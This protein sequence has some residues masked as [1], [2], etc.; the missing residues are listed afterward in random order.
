MERAAEDVLRLAPAPWLTPIAAALALALTACLA[1]AQ[2][3]RVAH[4]LGTDGSLHSYAY[5]LNDAGHVVGQGGPDGVC[6]GTTASRLV[7]LGIPST[8]ASTGYDINEHGRVTGVYYVS[9]AAHAMVWS[10]TSP[11]VD[12]GTLGSSGSIGRAINEAGAVVGSSGRAN[13]TLGAFL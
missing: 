11:L 12:L 9:G 13:G 3:L 5:G 2:P 8:N 10:P 7:P 4:D 1:E 6:R